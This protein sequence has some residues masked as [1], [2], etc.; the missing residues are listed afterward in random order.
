[1]GT[2]RVKA[3]FAPSLVATPRRRTWE[4]QPGWHCSV[5][6]TCLSLND[7]H[8]IARRARYHV[9]PGT[10][11]YR[12]HSCFVDM[13]V[14][15]NDLSKLVDK[16]LEKRHG[17]VAQF[18][19]GARDE[20][21]IE[22]RFK[23]AS[24]RGE[25]ASAY[26]GA[27]SH[28]LCTE[29]LQWGLFG[30]IHMLSHLMGSSRRADLA[31]VHD[32]E[33]CCA[34]LEGRLAQVKH[35]HRAGLKERRR[36]EDDQISRRR[37]A[38]LAERRLGTAQR[39][40]V[41]LESK[42]RTGELENRVAE[43]TERL[44][45]A[46]RRAANAE[47]A[48]SRTETLN[49]RLKA[50]SEQAAERIC[51]LAAENASLETELEA[52]LVCP[53]AGHQEA[54]PPTGVHTLSGKRILCVGGRPN[55]IQHYRALVERRGGEFLH[56]DG[57]LEESLDAVTRSMST[58]DAVVCPIDC[59]SHAATIKMRRACK[60]FSKELIVLRTSGLSSFARGIQSIATSTQQAHQ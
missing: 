29:K 60:H 30:E 34:S 1:M 26:W 5:L 41:E 16:T 23:E 56:H 49:Q 28:P 52:S 14:Y 46:Q 7:L 6:G 2:R 18:V 12:L 13:V 50:L 43:L 47:A 38:E 11:A 33:A 53:F 10:S 59:V 48:V 25:I 9:E 8:Q 42:S 44:E 40:I 3:S 4:L 51:E 45:A 35:D 24:A 15:Q 17:K 39:R 21:E 58:V 36:L 22:A 54:A 27:M 19:R 55:L 57:G 20:G 31:R 37:Q 32:L